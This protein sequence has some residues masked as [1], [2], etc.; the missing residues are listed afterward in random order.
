ML[1]LFLDTEFYRL[2]K[3]NGMQ[4]YY[5]IDPRQHHA[6]VDAKANHHG[7]WQGYQAGLQ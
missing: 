3:P 4:Q 1:T 7:W 5:N 6:L 2:R